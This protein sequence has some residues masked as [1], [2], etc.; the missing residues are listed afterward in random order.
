MLIYGREA[1]HKFL[2]LVTKYD[3]SARNEDEE[4]A[5]AFEAEAAD[6]TKSIQKLMKIT[7]ADPRGRD[8]GRDPPV[9]G[10][11]GGGVEKG[12][13]GCDPTG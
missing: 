13:L 12:R 3:L 2:E 1:R 11:C 9:S 6:H 5:G 7:E 10:C 4:E 8:P